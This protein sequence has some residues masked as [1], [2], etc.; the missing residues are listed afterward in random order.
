MVKININ[1]G[2]AIANFSAD[3][4][5]MNL[6]Y[7]HLLEWGRV[8]G[9]NIFCYRFAILKFISVLGMSC[10]HK[11]VENQKDVVV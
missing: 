2:Q 11:I 6:Y 10:V 4:W 5:K 1:L 3:T 9:M 8:I 7:L